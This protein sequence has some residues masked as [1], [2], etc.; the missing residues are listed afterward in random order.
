MAARH[1]AA[2]DMLGQRL[3]RPVPTAAPVR[4]PL[5]AVIVL[6][7]WVRFAHRP[8]ATFRSRLKL[9]ARARRRCRRVGSRVLVGLARARRRCRLRLRSWR[10]RR[11]VPVR[12]VG[13]TRARPL[14]RR[15][16]SG[17]RHAVLPSPLA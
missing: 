4:G 14:A 9:D 1:V 13:R 15:P 2:P 17:S 11:R 16:G 7:L 5:V 6:Q 3:P 10:L 12:L 8:A